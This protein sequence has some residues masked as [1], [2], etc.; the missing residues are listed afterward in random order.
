MFSAKSTIKRGGK[1]FPF[2]LLNTI[3]T[4]TCTQRHKQAHKHAW[5]ASSKEEK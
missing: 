3:V 4:P 5:Y 1:K 2:Q